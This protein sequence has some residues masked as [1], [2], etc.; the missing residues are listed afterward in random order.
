M[1]SK[2]R[3]ISTLPLE[4]EPDA[5]G[6]HWLT[7]SYTQKGISTIYKVNVNMGDIR[8]GEVPEK[9]RADNS[10]Y[11]KAAGISRQVRTK[12][13]YTAPYSSFDQ[14]LSIH[15]THSIL[16]TIKLTDRNTRE[17]DGIMKQVSMKSAGNFAF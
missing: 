11:P 7:F 16:V 6:I 14:L 13:I 10:V 2:K 4:I 1:T 3:S 8:D 12:V 9:F 5:D 15:L 17:I